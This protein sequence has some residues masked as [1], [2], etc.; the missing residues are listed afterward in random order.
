MGRRH[1]QAMRKAVKKLKYKESRFFPGKVL[2]K[3]GLLL[4]RVQNKVQ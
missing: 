1:K 2:L 3:C 4:P